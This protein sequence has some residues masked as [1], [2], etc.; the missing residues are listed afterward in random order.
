MCLKIIVAI[1]KSKNDLWTPIPIN[2]LREIEIEID[3]RQ[4]KDVIDEYCSK[5]RDKK[6]NN[7]K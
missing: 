7:V 3:E 4:E 1:F 5:K 6:E 2:T